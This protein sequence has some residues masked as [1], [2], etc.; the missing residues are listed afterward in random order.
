MEDCKPGMT[1]TAPAVTIS[2]EEINAYARQFDPQPFHTDAPAAK[3]TA[4]GGLIASGWHTASLTMRQMLECLPPME[5]GMIGRRIE[6]LDWPRPVH[7]GDSLTVSCEIVS[8][9]GTRNPERGLMRLKTET[10][11]QN[12]EAVLQMEALIFIPRRVPTI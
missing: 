7:P 12:G 11:N 8:V 2:A 5:G 1:F 3:A 9:R 4:F 10:R 6:N